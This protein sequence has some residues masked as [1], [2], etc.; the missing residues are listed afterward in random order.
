MCPV[1]HLFHTEK[2]CMT[3]ATKRSPLS[4]TSPPRP[5]KQRVT[6]EYFD[7]LAITVRLQ[8]ESGNHQYKFVINAQRWEE[9]PLILIGSPMSTARLIFDRGIDSLTAATPQTKEKP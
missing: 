6:F 7:L 5:V 4:R 9:D 1:G 3:P 8:L 2:G